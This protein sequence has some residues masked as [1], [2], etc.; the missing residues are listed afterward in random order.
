LLIMRSGFLA[1][2]LAMASHYG[3][4]EIHPLVR[5][6]WSAARGASHI[7]EEIEREID[8]CAQDLL[9]LV[10]GAVPD[11]EELVR[12]AQA[13]VEDVFVALALVASTAT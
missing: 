13:R 6:L 5:Q 12:A 3:D 8:G 9:T 1:M 7:P 4:Q 2:Q 11:R 10:R